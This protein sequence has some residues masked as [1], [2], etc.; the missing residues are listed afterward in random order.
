[1]VDTADLRHYTRV[2]TGYTPEAM[3]ARAADEMDALR[4]VLAAAMTTLEQIATT[5]RNRGAK[6]N[7]YATLKFIQTQLSAERPA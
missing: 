7:A 5:P 3:M 4:T 2:G 6:R 1:M